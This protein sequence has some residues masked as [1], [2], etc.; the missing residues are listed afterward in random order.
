MNQNGGKTHTKVHKVCRF[1]SHTKP[2]KIFEKCLRL[3]SS[4]RADWPPAARKPLFCGRR[5]SGL[6]S[7]FQFSLHHG[8]FIIHNVTNNFIEDG[9]SFLLSLNIGAQCTCATHVINEAKHEKQIDRREEDESLWFEYQVIIRVFS[10]VC[11]PAWLLWFSFSVWGTFFL[12]LFIHFVL[13][14]CLLMC[15]Y[16]DGAS[17]GPCK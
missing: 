1:V 14:F 13:Q 10:S 6:P 8:G 11:L 12:Y 4:T 16:T 15:F 7:A 17:K 5:S 9:N 2:G 3:N